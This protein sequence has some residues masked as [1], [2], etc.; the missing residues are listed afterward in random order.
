MAD[1]VDDAQVLSDMHLRH[2]LA[3]ARQ[4]VPIGVPG[5]CA[6][7]GDE[8]PRLVNNLCGYCRDGRR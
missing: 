3:A 5:E 6:K 2:S 1:V 4:P 8:M 7:C